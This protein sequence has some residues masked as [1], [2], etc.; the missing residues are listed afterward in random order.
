MNRRDDIKF[1]VSRAILLGTSTFNAD[2]PNLPPIPAALPSVHE[3]REL[4]ADTC[5]WPRLRITSLPNERHGG[6]LPKITKL[7]EDVEDVLIFYYVGHGLPIPQ[8]GRYDLGLALTDTDDTL[9]RRSSTSLRLRDLREQMEG[10]N[11][12]VKILIL[13]CC[14]AG[15]ATRYGGQIGGQGED[16]GSGRS[17]GTYIWAACGHTQR[18]YFE[19]HKKNGLTYFTKFLA[20][21]VRVAREQPPP[22]DDLAHLNDAVVHGLE[23]VSET[24]GF[25]VTPTPHVHHTGQPDDFRIVRSRGTAPYVP[26]HYEKLNESDPERI[27]PYEIKARLG[28]GGVGRVY[29]GTTARG[30]PVAVKVLHPEHGLDP[31]FAELFAMESKNAQKIRSPFVARILEA[32]AGSKPWLSMEYVCGPSLHELVKRVGPLPAG[33]IWKVAAAGDV[34]A[35]G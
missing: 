25:A 32:Q 23:R 9:T 13:D 12:R 34:G 14:F 7:I 8:D 15:I 18:T 11:A 26:Y 33:D 35:V 10:S 31:D 2:C 24:A 4:L 17:G 19:E 6:L 21:A 22:G 20:E 3:M 30:E 1:E 28:E 16:T 5:E 27:E 29:L